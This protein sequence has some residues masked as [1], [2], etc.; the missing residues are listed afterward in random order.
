VVEPRLAVD[1]IE[2]AIAAEVPLRWVTADTV[3]SVGGVEI[4]LR[5][6]GKGYVLGVNST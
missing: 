2:R 6:V 5:H 1:V 4:P 3:S